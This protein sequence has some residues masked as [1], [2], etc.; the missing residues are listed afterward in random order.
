MIA[1]F[2]IKH[3]F[4]LE[5]EIVVMIGSK[6]QKGSL[7]V[8]VKTKQ[9]WEKEDLK[10]KLRAIFSLS[11]TPPK[12]LI[13][14]AAKPI[15]MLDLFGKTSDYGDKLFDLIAWHNCR[16]WDLTAMTESDTNKADAIES[17]T[18]MTR[19]RYEQSADILHLNLLDRV[20][21]MCFLTHPMIVKIPVVSL[22][23]FLNIHTHF[24][25]NSI[26]KAKH[27]SR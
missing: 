18:I 13:K 16:E 2:L 11:W 4:G 25:F 5:D 1:D 22:Q 3:L 12:S 6:T 10:N 21:F 17:M 26:R 19:L 24:A 15:F 8:A 23:Y 14:E 9:L 27:P 7:F 20:P